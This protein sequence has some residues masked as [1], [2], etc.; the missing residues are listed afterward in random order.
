[1]LRVRLRRFQSWNLVNSRWVVC[2]QSCRAPAVVG[3]LPMLA[4]AAQ[5]PARVSQSHMDDGLP[6]RKVWNKEFLCS[7]SRFGQDFSYCGYFCVCFNN[8][9]LGWPGF[10]LCISGQRGDFQI[11]ICIHLLHSIPVRAGR[12]LHNKVSRKHNAIKASIILFCFF[13]YLF[14]VL[15]IHSHFILFILF[16]YS[17]SAGVDVMNKTE[18]QVSVRGVQQMINLF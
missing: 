4:T 16:L 15:K 8:L 5:K 6:S 7:G 11:E 18:M 2:W 3:E 12:H 9:L 17:Y 14:P 10:H 13:L 1:M